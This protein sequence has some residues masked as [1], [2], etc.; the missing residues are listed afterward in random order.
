M[1][2]VQIHYIIDTILYQWEYIISMII[3]YANGATL[4]QW[5]ASKY[6]ISMRI[7]KYIIL[8]KLD[9]INK[10]IQIHYNNGNPLFQCIRMCEFIIS[11][12]SVQTPDYVAN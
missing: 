8:M 3:H 7:Y 11:V 2:S 10:N 4:Y 9:H 5:I 12:N 6:I 1:N